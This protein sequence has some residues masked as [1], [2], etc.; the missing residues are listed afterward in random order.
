MTVRKE[1]TVLKMKKECKKIIVVVIISKIDKQPIIEMITITAKEMRHIA[2]TTTS[3][4]QTMETDNIIKN[5]IA[6]TQ[7]QFN[8]SKRKSTTLK[9]SQQLK[10]PMR[11]C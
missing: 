1:T 6:I 9:K 4:N 7:S 5:K 11:K 8:K 3:R 10:S 2:M